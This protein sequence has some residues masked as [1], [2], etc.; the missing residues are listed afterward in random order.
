M[1]RRGITLDQQRKTLIGPARS[2]SVANHA[3]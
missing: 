3:D 2:L 1:A